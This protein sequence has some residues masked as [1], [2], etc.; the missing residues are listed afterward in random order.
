MVQPLKLPATE[1]VGLR[2][3]DPWYSAMTWRS[4]PPLQTNILHAYDELET[5]ENEGGRW[6]YK[7]HDNDTRTLDLTSFAEGRSL[8]VYTELMIALCESSR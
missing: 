1:P 4:L 2:W 3:N 7:I 8:L 6:P 5:I